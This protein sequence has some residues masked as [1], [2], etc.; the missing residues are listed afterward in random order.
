MLLVAYE[1]STPAVPSVGPGTFK[2]GDSTNP[3]QV[4]FSDRTGSHSR[5]A[6]CLWFVDGMCAHVGANAANFIPKNPKDSQFYVIVHVGNPISPRQ[7]G[8]CGSSA[9][10]KETVHL[11]LSV[12]LIVMQALGFATPTFTRNVPNWPTRDTLTRDQSCWTNLTCP[13]PA[14]QAG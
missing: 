3:K 8:R 5:R 10:G 9:R 7:I 2:V 11:H 4:S 1:S 6:H 14:T 13:D 12:I